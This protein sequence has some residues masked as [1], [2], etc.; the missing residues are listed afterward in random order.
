MVTS[1]RTYVQKKVIACGTSA[2]ANTCH[3]LR[4]I[5]LYFR[6]NDVLFCDPVSICGIPSCF[7][8]ISFIFSRQ[9]LFYGALCSY[10]WN[11]ILFFG[12]YIYL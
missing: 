9:C 1:H 11:T 10:L 4:S 2:T 12:N 8:F 5:R 6:E 7:W 3:L